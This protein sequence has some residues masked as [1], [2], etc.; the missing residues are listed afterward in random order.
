LR[1]YLTVGT[2]N[3]FDRLVRACDE[4]AASDPGQ[5]WLAQ[6]HT[7]SYEPTH[8]RFERFVDKA[9]WDAAMLEADA[10]VG[11]AGMGTISAALALG[12]PLLVMP[13]RKAYGES[14]ND[15]QRVGAEHFRA[16]GHLLVAEDVVD[17]R[18]GVEALRTFV[19]VPRRIDAGRLADD[20]G[21][22]LRRC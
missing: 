5:D 20:I 15:H 19:P 14:V 22:F 6:I 11:H 2:L 1:I 3:P 18:S 4:L 13:R 7:G 21:D 8:M 12:K 9:R 17:L 10:I 16:G